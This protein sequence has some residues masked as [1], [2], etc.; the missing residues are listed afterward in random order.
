MKP[1]YIEGARNIKRGQCLSDSQATR[2]RRLAGDL[3]QLENTTGG[4]F[5]MTT[6][7]DMHSE[8]AKALNKFLRALTQPRR[9]MK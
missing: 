3:A 9:S 8:P 1:D 2:L 4:L 5:H 6:H 7:V